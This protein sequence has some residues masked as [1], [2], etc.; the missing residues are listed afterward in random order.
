[1]KTQGVVFIIYFISFLSYA[2]QKVEGYVLEKETN[3]P[4]EGATVYY[5]GTTIGIITNPSGYFSI[6]SKENNKAALIV[7]YLGYDDVYIA[8]PGTKP[9]KIILSPSAEALGQVFIDANPLFKRKEMLAAF[10]EQFLGTSKGSRNCIIKNEDVLSFYFDKKK[11]QLIASAD[12]PITIE[13]RYLGYTIKYTLYDFE[14]DY[15]RKSLHP[16][17]LKKSFYAGTS[18]YT[19]IA[20]NEKKYRKRREKTFKGSTLHFM[21]YI[22]NEQWKE[23][24]DYVFFRK[25]FKVKPES[26]LLVSDTLNLKQITLN[27]PINILYKKKQQS[28]IEN[29]YTSFFIDGYGNFYPPDGL[30][31]TGELGKRRMGDALPL[32][33]NLE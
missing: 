12:G 15:R 22:A 10:K 2:Q 25:Q 30:L 29:K 28:K 23:A 7:S 5:E 14:L 26:A 17:A 6:T 9:L 8:S 13:N 27:H 20:T 33:Y 31:F 4:L 19:D 21:R 1:M 16:S 24:N 11:N 3:T 32:N 18:F